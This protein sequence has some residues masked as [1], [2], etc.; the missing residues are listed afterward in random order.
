M[1]RRQKDFN[2]LL[3][4]CKKNK[5]AVN[6]KNLGGEA[7]WLDFEKKIIAICPSYT[8]EKRIYYF[9][10][11]LGHLLI[12][13]DRRYQAEKAYGVLN[14]SKK[15]LTSKVGEIEEE[16]EAWHRGRRLAKRLG[17]TINRRVFEMV[18]SSA[19]ATYFRWATKD[20]KELR[21]Q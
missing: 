21:N 17:I 4:Y 5:I 1:S 7:G 10:H 8:L 19:L 18:K 15:S 16:F 20:K 12:A 6:I 3:A 9:L 11:E 14:F 13:K 2:K